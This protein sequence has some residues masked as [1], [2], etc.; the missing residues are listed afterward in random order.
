VEDN[1]G[2]IGVE[3]KARKILEVPNNW[4]RNRNIILDKNAKSIGN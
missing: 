2:K 4:S 3:V 1:K